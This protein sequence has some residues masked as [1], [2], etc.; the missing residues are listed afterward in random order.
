[1]DKDG[2]YLNHEVDVRR[3]V[4]RLVVDRGRR[5]R[6]GHAILQAPRFVKFFRIFQVLSSKVDFR[7]SRLNFPSPSVGRRWRRSGQSS[8]FPGAN[9]PTW[10]TF[11]GLGWFRNELWLLLEMGGSL[12]FDLS[13]I[14]RSRSFLFVTSEWFIQRSA[15]TPEHAHNATYQAES[16][17]G[18]P[19]S[20]L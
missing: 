17:S 6:H 5:G 14:Q 20:C 13:S 1:M 16:S 4:L 8:H 11:H 15:S 9:S 10:I 18:G 12:F 3:L 2:N 19:N 7:S